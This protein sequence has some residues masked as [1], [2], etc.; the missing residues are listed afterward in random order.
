[1]ER[2]LFAE[3][4]DTDYGQFDLIWT[5]DDDYFG[6]EGDFDVFFDGQVNG[7]VGGA[8]PNG[9]YMNLARRSGDREFVSPS[10]IRRRR[11]PRGS[12]KT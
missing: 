11:H 5:E 3:V 2:N 9:L 7:L 6:F 12:G 8:N 4:I 1:M 10:S